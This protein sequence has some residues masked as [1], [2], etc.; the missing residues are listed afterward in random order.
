MNR[1]QFFTTTTGTLG[2]VALESL[3]L[4]DATGAVPNPARRFPTQVPKVKN[5]IQLFMVGAASHIDTFDHKPLLEKKHGQPWEP[6]GSVELFASVP[7]SVMRPPWGWKPYGQSGKLINDCVAPIGDVVDDIAFIHNMTAESN[8]HSPA[9]FHQA[10]GFTRPG[11]PGAGAWVSYALGSENDNLPSYVVLP[12]P[13]G[14]PTNGVRNWASG[15]L[16]AQ[17]QGTVIEPHA[18]EPIRNLFPAGARRD[19]SNV[20]GLLPYLDQLNQAHAATRPGDDRLAARLESYELAAGLQLA[21]ADLFDL[22]D[23]PVHIRDLYGLD[24]NARPQRDV[25][26]TPKGEREAFG[27][28]CLYARRLVERGVR[29]VQVWCGADNTPSIRFNWDSHNS[30]E[31]DHGPLGAG[32]ANGVRALITDLKQR[33]LYDETLILWTTEFGRMPCTE[34]SLGR[35]HNPFCFT[36]WMA[37]GG[38]KGGTS[39]GQSDEWGWKPAEGETTCHDI[40]ATMLHLLGIPFKQLSVPHNGLDE[41]LT[42][43][44]G[45]VL[46]EILT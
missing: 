33:G 15:F 36:Q 18:A 43:V 5:V 9:I 44:H 25:L 34:G 17:H 10:T 4:R 3:F 19:R 12:D 35:D 11:Y 30:I 22:S 32:M 21:S 45:R 2:G 39:L 1:R 8:V 41:R 6:G 16:P 40:Y 27:R 31:R 37:G 42:S 26:M 20:A 7:G 28:N 23:E 13:R 24:E 14:M 38:V 29:F 46:G